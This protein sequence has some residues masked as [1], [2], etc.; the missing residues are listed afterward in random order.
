MTEQDRRPIDP[1]TG[2]FPEVERRGHGPNLY[3]D[4]RHPRQRKSDHGW[5]YWLPWLYTH[6]V[7]AAAIV[8][9]AFAVGA[10]S[11]ASSKAEHNAKVARDLS[12]RN[13]QAVVA[14]QEGRRAAIGESCVQDERI[15]DVVRKALLGFGVGRPGNPAPPRVAEAFRPLGGLKPLSPEEQRARC[16]ARV[17]R[18]GP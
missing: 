6:M 11:D 18:G 3:D 16:N 17:R 2:E 15:A 5:R 14:I 4:G 10:A 7:P 13:R 12:A 1:A 8:V 9:A